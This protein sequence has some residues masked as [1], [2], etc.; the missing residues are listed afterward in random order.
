MVIG[1][2]AAEFLFQA[3]C[4]GLS[5]VVDPLFLFL[6]WLG[7]QLPQG[8]FLWLWG[9]GLGFLKDVATGGLFGSFSC[10]FGLIGWLLATAR[11]MAEREDPLIQSF[12]AGILTALHGLLYGVILTL[13]D[14]AVGWRAGWLGWWF[15]SVIL[16]VGCA[17]WGYPRLKRT[18]TY[19]L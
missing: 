15:L 10:T 7:L 19:S 2:W 5:L 6:V 4:P 1:L 14:P 12:W 18:L 8:R 3:L 13:A 9:V 16:S 11:H 17:A